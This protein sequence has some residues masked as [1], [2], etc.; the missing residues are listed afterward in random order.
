MAIELVLEGK[1]EKESEKEEFSAFLKE[2]CKQKQLKI[3]DYDTLVL[4]D[5]CPEGR[6][7]CSYIILV[8]QWIELMN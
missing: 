3:E 1:L 4:I 8:F 2:L 7:E 5:V 6:I